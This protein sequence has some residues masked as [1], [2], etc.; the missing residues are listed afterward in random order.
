MFFEWWSVIKR[1]H[2]MNRNWEELDLSGTGNNLLCHPSKS[3]CIPDK[4]EFSLN[5][6]TI[7]D[8][9]CNLLPGTCYDWSTRTRVKSRRITITVKNFE[10][11]GNGSLDIMNTYGTWTISRRTFLLRRFFEEPLRQWDDIAFYCLSVNCAGEFVFVFERREL[12]TWACWRMTDGKQWELLITECRV[13]LSVIVVDRSC[14]KIDFPTSWTL[15]L[16]F[17]GSFYHSKQLD[18]VKAIEN[19]FASYFSLIIIQISRLNYNQPMSCKDFNLIKRLTL[20][21][22]TAFFGSGLLISA[23]FLRESLLN[24]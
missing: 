16:S 4:L 24:T 12:P 7:S 14:K 15:V 9:W 11:V 18:G 20:R 3:I 1:Y 22:P 19:A 10:S 6:I 8:K 21:S 17:R 2:L 5:A 13:T 23:Y